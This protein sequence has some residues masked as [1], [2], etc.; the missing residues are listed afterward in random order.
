M[1]IDEQIKYWT[2]ISEYDLSTADV[3]LKNKK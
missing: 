2:E 3:M 1:D